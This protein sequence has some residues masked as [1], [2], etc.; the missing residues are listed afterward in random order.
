M[1]TRAPWG[2]GLALGLALLS[3][4][5][6]TP[7][8]IAQTEINYLLGFIGRSGCEFYRNGTWYDPKRAQAHLRYKYEMLAARDQIHTAEDFIEKAATQ[9]SLS[10]QPY[11]VRCRDGEAVMSNQWLS[12]VLARYRTHA[13]WGAPLPARGA[14]G[15]DSTGQTGTSVIFLDCD[16]AVD[17]LYMLCG[18]RNG[19]GLVRRFL[20]PGVAG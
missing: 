18:A 15:I 14:L 8:A 2:L 10:G 13:A 4:A 16:C 12:D 17:R 6:A 11:Q 7:P 19:Y 1:N 9:S 20:G 3:V 5:R